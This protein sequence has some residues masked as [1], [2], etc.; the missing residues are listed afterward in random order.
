MAASVSWLHTVTVSP[1][2]RKAPC[3]TAKHTCTAATNPRTYT[4]RACA[5]TAAKRDADRILNLPELEKS[6]LSAHP[7]ARSEKDL[8]VLDDT[9]AKTAAC[10]ALSRAARIE[11]AR[12][13]RLQEFPPGSVIVKRGTPQESVLIVVGGTATR[14]GISFSDSL[15][16]NDSIGE[17]HTMRPATHFNVFTTSR[18][19]RT[20]HR[21]IEGMKKGEGAKARAAQRKAAD[22]SVARTRSAE[23]ALAKFRQHV[24]RAL[25]R[26]GRWAF[27]VTA[28]PDAP[29]FCAVITL[30]QYNRAQARVRAS[31]S[32]SA[33]ERYLQDS[34]SLQASLTRDQVRSLAKAMKV[35]RVVDYAQVYRQGTEADVLFVLLAG[36]VFL[37][38][39]LTVEGASAD[40]LNRLSHKVDSLRGA[41]STK[42]CA[43]QVPSK[44]PTF[45][46]GSFFRPNDP[47]PLSASEREAAE[48]PDRPTGPTKRSA[49]TA[50][51]ITSVMDRL[52]L[53]GTTGKEAEVQS[54][55]RATLTTAAAGSDSTAAPKP[56]G[57][58]AAAA[59]AA[60]SGVAADS[61]AAGTAVRWADAVLQASGSDLDQPIARR[62]APGSSISVQVAHLRPGS[63]FGEFILREDTE[64]RTV[65]TCSAVAGTSAEL[66]CLSRIDAQRLDAELRRVLFTRVVHNSPE[67]YAV[68]LTEAE[69]LKSQLGGMLQWEQYKKSVVNGL[70]GRRVDEGH[71][72]PLPD[73]TGFRGLRVR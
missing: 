17:L 52:W 13:A 67:Q 60:L 51:C 49:M 38:R 28:G 56:A 66:G 41:I 5:P 57:G 14:V 39:E 10:E 16:D 8:D 44:M 7:D 15:S 37:H 24:K 53:V 68:V 48:R 33:L 45:R 6:I 62:L 46:A 63:V 3:L 9:F 25:M 26:V 36:D 50:K 22:T 12:E 54:S 31:W 1:P 43:L 55:A 27:T 65:H 23:L 73:K 18:V 19:V 34:P 2:A 42:A 58:G 61:A 40:E 11:L 69:Q 72:K 70:M 47:A 30:E 59:A 32:V 20:V 64:R 71:G 21:V 35:R 4:P 29:V